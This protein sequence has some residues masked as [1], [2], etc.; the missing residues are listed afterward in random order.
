MPLFTSEEIVYA[1]KELVWERITNLEQI[2]KYFPFVEGAYEIDDIYTKWTL[3]AP[4]LPES[5]TKYFISNLSVV[6]PYVCIQWHS[7]GLDMVL[8]GT[9]MIDELD[10][11]RCK[12]KT[13][14]HVIIKDSTKVI[15]N[16]LMFTKIKFDLN[17][18]M[19]RLIEK[20]YE[21]QEVPVPLQEQ[22]EL[23]Q[24]NKI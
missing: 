12:I 1:S 19:Q 10:N 11:G 2:G 20:I 15:P 22:Y 21:A 7:E 6:Y 24:Y 17:N 23:V 5:A 8:K 9:I 4:L 3:K 13:N 16:Q 18:F 14:L